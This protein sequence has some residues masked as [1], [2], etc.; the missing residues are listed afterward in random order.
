MAETGETFSDIVRLSVHGLQKHTWDVCGASEHAERAVEE[1]T[2][3]TL[4]PDASPFSTRWVWKYRANVPALNQKSGAS[5]DRSARFRKER[6]LV[7]G[8]GPLGDRIV[9]AL[10]DHPSYELI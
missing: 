7:L 9:A 5:I 8:D 1:S 3:P 4:V 2:F 6:V 10:Q